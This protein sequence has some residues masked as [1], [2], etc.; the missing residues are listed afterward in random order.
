MIFFTT[1]IFY[2]RTYKE[3]E[4]VRSSNELTEFL[5]ALQKFIPELSVYNVI[6]AFRF[7]VDFQLP[8]DNDLVTQIVCRLLSEIQNIPLHL[9]VSVYHMLVFKS[10]KSENKLIS[11]FESELKKQIETHLMKNVN[12]FSNSDL[13]QSVHYINVLSDSLE[14]WPEEALV[15]LLDIIFS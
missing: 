6:S 11:N 8:S 14:H 15:S 2:F 3:K 9:A 13:M 12:D 10:Y 4:K 5:K 1:F 7:C